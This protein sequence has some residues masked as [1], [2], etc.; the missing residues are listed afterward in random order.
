MSREVLIL[1]QPEIRALL[2]PQACI[3]AMEQA[4]AAYATGQ[5]E[6]PG[7]IHLDIPESDV[8]EKR[9]EIHVKAG[10]LH[11]GPYYAVKIVSGFA[12]NS[13]P[14]SRSSSTMDLSPASALEPPARSPRNILRARKL[15]QSR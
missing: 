2:D 5:A 7:V 10:Y 14:Q 15:P 11:G 8:S 12:S 1:R 6:L 4:F 9:G 13:Q 3:A